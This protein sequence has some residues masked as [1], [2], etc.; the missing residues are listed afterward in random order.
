MLKYF[1]G[2]IIL[3]TLVFTTWIVKLY[4]E[5]KDDVDKIVYYQPKQTTQ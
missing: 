2:F 3:S 1:M 5:I 4:N